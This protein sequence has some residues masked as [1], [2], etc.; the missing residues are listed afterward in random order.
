MNNPLTGLKLTL[1]E[2]PYTLSLTSKNATLSQT[3]TYPSPVTVRMT[4][5]EFG[6]LMSMLERILGTVEALQELCPPGSLTDD[7][8]IEMTVGV[9]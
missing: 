8:L 3:N 6:N 1:N 4:L 2:G 5:D 7:N 9:E